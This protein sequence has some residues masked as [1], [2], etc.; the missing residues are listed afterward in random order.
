MRIN[1]EVIGI[2][3]LQNKTDSSVQIDLRVMNPLYKNLIKNFLT[4]LVGA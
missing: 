1:E 3:D 2:F 4:E